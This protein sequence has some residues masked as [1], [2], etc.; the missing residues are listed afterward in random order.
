MFR[1]TD[2]GIC[3]INLPFSQNFKIYFF[4]GTFVRFYL[5][6]KLDTDFCIIIAFRFFLTLSMF[7]NRY[8]VCPKLEYARC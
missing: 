5:Q 4:A 2:P 7:A 1:T 6:G 3:Q 8:T